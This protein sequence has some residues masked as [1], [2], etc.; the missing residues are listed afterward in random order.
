MKQRTMLAHDKNGNKMIV[1][2][3][4][5]LPVTSPCA[6]YTGYKPET[7][8]LEKRLYPAERLYATTV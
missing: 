7:V 5:A 3:R 4:S 2:V 6:R 1:K 8:L